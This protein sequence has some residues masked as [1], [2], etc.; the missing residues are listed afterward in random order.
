MPMIGRLYIAWGGAGAS[1]FLL[2]GA[3]AAVCLLPPTL[4]MGATLPAITRW[5]ETTPEGISWL[6]FFYAGNIAGAVGGSLLAGFYLLRVYDMASRRASLRRSSAAVAVV[7]VGLAGRQVAGRRGHQPNGRESARGRSPA[8]PMRRP[9]TERS[10]LPVYIAIALSGFCALAAE[11]VWTRL[12]RSCSALR[13]TPS[14][15]SWPYS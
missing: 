7:A 12:L 6:G 14:P 1:G 10:R 5:V 15:S 8:A 3:V 4:A 9:V 11:V 13:S 2:R